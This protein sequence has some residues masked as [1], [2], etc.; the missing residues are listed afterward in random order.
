MNQKRS[1]NI[2]LG[3]IF[4]IKQ[5]TKLNNFN[6]LFNENKDTLDDTILKRYKTKLKLSRTYSEELNKLFR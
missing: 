3:S 1:V 5:D 4:Y 6:I 2:L